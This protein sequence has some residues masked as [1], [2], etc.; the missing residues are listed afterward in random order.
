MHIAYAKMPIMILNRN[1]KNEHPYLVLNNREQPASLSPLSRTLTI[2]FSDMPFVTEEVSIL[3]L[4][5][6]WIGDIYIYIY[7]FI[8]N[9]DWR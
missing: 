1:D 3:L 8:F 5:C 2:C 7:L 4:F 6:S 9:E